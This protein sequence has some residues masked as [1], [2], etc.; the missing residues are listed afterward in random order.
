M[1]EIVLDGKLLTEKETAHEYLQEILHFPE[2]YGKNLD[3]LYD[4]LTD[5][6][7]TDIVIMVPE[8]IEEYLKRVL[9]VFKTAAKENQNLKLNMIQEVE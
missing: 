6:A 7:D 2:Y 9:R 1:K 5:L 3:A 8:E 4:C